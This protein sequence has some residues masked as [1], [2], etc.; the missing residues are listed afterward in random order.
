MVKSS[1]SDLLL[2]SSSNPEF[3]TL[4]VLPLFASRLLTVQ[5]LLRLPTLL[6]ATNH[7][8]T[9]KIENFGHPLLAPG[10]MQNLQAVLS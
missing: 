6:W 9:Y 3:K 10:N 8:E 2:P 5:A 4:Q 7:F 1:P